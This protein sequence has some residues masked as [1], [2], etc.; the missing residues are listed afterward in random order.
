MLAGLIQQ[1]KE[2]LTAHP[3]C[4]HIGSDM[5]DGDFVRTCLDHEWPQ[6]TGFGHADMIALLAGDSEPVA[7]KHFDEDAVVN[8]NEFVRLRHARR[9]RTTAQPRSA[10]EEATGGSVWTRAKN[11]LLPALA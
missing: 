3:G 1:L 8:G 4:R 10:L 2:A 7:F 6:D 11:P 9:T 5:G